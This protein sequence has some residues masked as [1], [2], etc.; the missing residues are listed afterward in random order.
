MTVTPY[1]RKRVQRVPIEPQPR[2]NK[3]RSARTRGNRPHAGDTERRP[4]PLAPRGGGLLREQ[5]RA[6]RHKW[7]TIRYAI[8]DTGRT[9]RLCVIL[10]FLAAGTAVAPVLIILLR[11]HSG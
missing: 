5:R 6:A 11:G 7:G 10:V 4:G 8:D 2:M 3:S 1:P 9:V